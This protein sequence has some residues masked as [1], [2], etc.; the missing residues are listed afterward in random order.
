MSRA[1]GARAQLALAFESAYGTPPAADSY[2][3]MPFAASGLGS[4][5]PLLASDLLG[6]G[7]D[8]RA[9]VL[10]AITAG[11]D[12]RIPFDQRYL[13]I[14]LKSVFGEPDSSDPVAAT[15]T[16]TFSGQPG[17]GSEITINGIPFAFVASSPGSD[18]IEIGATLPDT[19]DN[20]IAELNTS[21]HTEVDDATY[22][23]DGTDALTITHDTAG[24]AGNAF[25]LAAA[26]ASNGT[27]SAST[28]RGG[29]YL[30]EF[31][32]GLWT[33]PSF[34]VETGM[35]DVP[36][37]AMVSGCVTDSLAL[38]M[39][40]SGLVRGTVNVVAQGEAAPA[41]ASAAGTLTELLLAEFG[42][43]HGEIRR[44]GSQLA[45]VT[46]GSWTY[47][48]NLQRIETIR[49]DGL[50]DGAD[51]SIASD[52]G[53]IQVLFADQTLLDQARD[54]E[55][56]E[57]QFNY[58]NPLGPYLKKIVHEVYL[59]RPQRRL[60]GPQGVTVTF[61]WQAAKNAGAGRMTTVQLLNDVADYDNPS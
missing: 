47:A 53:Q 17:A 2:W 22:T 24:P 25:T 54:G 60:E 37:F 33:L 14:W 59:P 18:E 13:G 26:A 30:H 44:D 20:I 27:V 15:G 23:E 3:Q 7:R 10:D 31:H 6:F 9:P 48:N 19:L 57:L 32:S 41:A 45:N 40:R 56:C 21:V 43:F 61:D 34:S 39:N 5:Q 28:L 55:P 46:R 42:P 29:G 36:D 1:Q 16:I 58:V 4:E 8:P 38:E 11:G 52:T 12:L 51:P 35:P 49:S 50:I